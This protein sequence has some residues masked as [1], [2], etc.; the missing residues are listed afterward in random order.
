VLVLIL[1]DVFYPLNIADEYK[2]QFQDSLGKKITS[3]KLH[4][5]GVFRSISVSWTAALQQPR[6]GW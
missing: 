2:Q 3:P 5:I 1:G 4:G 6:H